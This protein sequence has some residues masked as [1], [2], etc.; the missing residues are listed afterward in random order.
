MKTSVLADSLH[1]SYDETQKDCFLD[2]N[3]QFI[4]ILL[5]LDVRIPNQMS[6]ENFECPTHIKER[7]ALLH[8]K[9]LERK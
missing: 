2:E 9:Y 1:V 4:S 3:L 5:S 8:Q 7:W 6:G